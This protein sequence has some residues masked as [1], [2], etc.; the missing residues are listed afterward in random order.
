MIGRDGL[1]IAPIPCR[2]WEGTAILQRL[3][4]NGFAGIGLPYLRDEAGVFPEM[5][6][7]RVMAGAAD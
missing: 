2:C 4:G 3:R 7:G 1:E 5:E 6:T